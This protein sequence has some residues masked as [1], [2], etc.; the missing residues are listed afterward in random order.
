MFY[1][2]AQLLILW[3]QMFAGNRFSTM[4]DRAVVHLRTWHTPGLQAETS[5]HPASGLEQEVSA[6]PDAP[7]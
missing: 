4:A 3:L 1:F 7:R 5:C 6:G 2:S